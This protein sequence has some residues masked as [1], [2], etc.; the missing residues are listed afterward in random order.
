MTITFIMVMIMLSLVFRKEFRK[1]NPESKLSPSKINTRLGQISNLNVIYRSIYVSE[2]STEEEKN[3][4]KTNIIML[5]RLKN[6]YYAN[7]QNGYIGLGLGYTM[8]GRIL[9]CVEAI[10]VLEKIL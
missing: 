1:N 5:Q 8:T 6:L 7:V 4:A 3:R 9:L 10:L 2:N